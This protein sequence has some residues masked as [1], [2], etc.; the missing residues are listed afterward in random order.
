MRAAAIQMLRNRFHF[1]AEDVAA[2]AEAMRDGEATGLLRD[3]E[4]PEAGPSTAPIIRGSGY[5]PTKRHKNGMND[6]WTRRRRVLTSRPDTNT[7]PSIST[8]RID[9]S[10]SSE[11]A[12]AAALAVVM[13][14]RRV[15]EEQKLEE[16][17]ERVLYESSVEE[18][19]QERSQK[20]K[21]GRK[22]KGRQDPEVEEEYEG[23][24]DASSE[25]E[26]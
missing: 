18:M 15:E 17:V 8:P 11:E 24:A 22:G 12:R 21:G 7:N 2:L 16:E 19:R 26:K 13:E 5:P 23:E 4:T 25:G 1:E 20:N 6:S 3:V 9:I 10:N 14:R